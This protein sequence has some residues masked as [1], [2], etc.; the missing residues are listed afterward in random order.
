MSGDAQCEWA[1]WFRAH[2][3]HN[4]LPSNFDS[5]N[6][7]HNRLLQR[8]KQQLEND[9]FKVL[10]EAQNQFSIKG[11]D[12]RTVIGGKPDI[13]AIK[14]PIDWVIEDVKTGQQ[15][16]SHLAQ[17]LIYM[18]LAPF[19]LPKCRGHVMAGRL[20][21]A[22]NVVEVPTAGLTEEFKETFRATVGA[23][24]GDAPAFRIPSH[25]ECSWCDISED[26]CEDRIN[27]APDQTID[28]DLF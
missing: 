17:M 16:N 4:R 14:Q 1:M 19:G 8:R 22:E 11:K 7:E 24:S 6:L 25:Q 9:G 26:Y 10:V 3:K 13:V 20:V 18:L 12:G 28:H 15:R 21:Y 23:I 5:W 27:E 2:Y